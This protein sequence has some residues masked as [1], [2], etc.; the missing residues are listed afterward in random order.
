MLLSLSIVTHLSFL[1]VYLVNLQ[2][3]FHLEI[4]MHHI[5]NNLG[6]SINLHLPSLKAHSFTKI[7][8][9]EKVSYSLLVLDKTT[10]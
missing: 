9:R 5:T 6:T 2:Q 7:I 8:F 1:G 3:Y 10:L 4:S